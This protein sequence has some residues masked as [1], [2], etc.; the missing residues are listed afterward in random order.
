MATW[1]GQRACLLKDKEMTELL[2]YFASWK[3]IL[4]PMLDNVIIS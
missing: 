1:K 2:E 4:K 3:I